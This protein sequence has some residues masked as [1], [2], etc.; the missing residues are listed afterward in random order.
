MDV[1]EFLDRYRR[2]IRELKERSPRSVEPFLSFYSQVM[3]D[4]VLSLK[5]KELIALAVGVTIHCEHCVIIHARGAQKAG[6]TLEEIFEAAQVGVV[7]GGGPA[8]TFLPLLQ[9]VLSHS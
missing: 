3:Q 9:E 2:G 6:A 7:M 5:V 8:F 1:Q 4:G